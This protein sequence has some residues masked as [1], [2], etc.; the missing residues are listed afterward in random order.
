M[1]DLN[2]GD[3]EYIYLKECWEMYKIIEWLYYIPETS[4]AMYAN[5]TSIIIIIKYQPTETK[6]RKTPS[7]FNQEKAINTSEY[8]WR[9]SL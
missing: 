3:L 1:G 2:K 9:R 8:K 6:E 7:S 5:Y 4:I